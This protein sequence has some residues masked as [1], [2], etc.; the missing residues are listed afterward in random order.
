M[1]KIIIF[2]LL[3]SL[4]IPNAIFAS[5]A[6]PSAIPWSSY[7]N[8]PSADSTFWTAA[9]TVWPTVDAANAAAK[10]AWASDPDNIAWTNFSLNVNS[11]TPWSTKY[12]WWANDNV[13]E[14][15]KKIAKL[16]LV[17]IPTLAVLFMVIG[18][19]KIMLAGWDSAKIKNW[20][21]III[22]NI[23]AVAL[24]LL[25]WSIVQLIIWTI[26]SAS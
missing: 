10:A 26:W 5:T 13:A 23:T 14:I 25:S 2:T 4:L 15:L 20:R 21:A 19:I 3:S 22:Y 12:T 9:P 7:T 24:A 18:A 1:K 8:A 17:V 6:T 11:L 16:L